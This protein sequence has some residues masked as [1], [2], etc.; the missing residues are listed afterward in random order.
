MFEW[1]PRFGPRSR[2]PPTDP[3][4]AIRTLAALHQAGLSLPSLWAELARNRRFGDIPVA[5]IA[6]MD[7]GVNPHDALQSLATEADPPWRALGA[8][9][10]IA[11]VSGAPLGPALEALA[12]ALGDISRTQRQI[13]AALAGPKA[14]MRLVMALPVIGIIGGELGGQSSLAFLV[15]TGL[16]A[17]LFALGA[18][19]MLGAWWWLRLLAERAK[20]DPA[21]LGLE[22][23]LFAIATGGGALPERAQDLVT[24][25]CSEYSL[26]VGEADSLHNL[27]SLSRRAGVPV[28]G[29]ARAG[30]RARRDLGRTNAEELMARLG[31]SVVMPLGL[32]VLPA[33]V[34]VAVVPMAVSLWEGALA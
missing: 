13:T 4:E 14:T 22:M 15:G 16:G 9:W 11:R 10:A 8:C 2:K 28:A 19:M 23:D 21:A 27:V 30:A 1:I 33:F 7:D 6:E 5:I 3:V 34:L 18:A 29:L 25:V 26:D 32:L 31:V 24:K 20:P 17:S 12:E